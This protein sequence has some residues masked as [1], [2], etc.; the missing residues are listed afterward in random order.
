MNTKFKTPILL[1]EDNAEDASLIKG[2]LEDVGFKYELYHTE[3][4]YEG[5]ELIH[6]TPI[7]IVLL[8]LNLPDSSGFKTITSYLEKSA[9]VPVIVIT[10]MNNEII[11]NQAVKAGAQDFLIKGQFDSKIF[12]RSVRYSLQRSKVQ[13]KLEETARELEQSKKRFLDAQ[14]MAHLGTWDMDIVSSEMTWSDEVYRIFSFMPGG[15]SPTLSEYLTFVPLEDRPDVEA[16]F[17]NAAKDGRLH[18]IEHRI[19]I[20]STNIRYVTIQGKVQVDDTGKIMLAGN[21]QDT[22]ER[23]MSEKLL[24]EKNISSQTAK[25]QEAVLADLSFQIRTPLS[26]I[27]NLLFL[28]ENTDTGA[29]ET[30]YIGDLK[31]SVSDLSLSVNNLL[32]FSV[33]V[34]DNV[35]VEEEEFNIHEFLTGTQNIVK[36]KADSAKLPLKFNIDQQLPEKITGDPKKITQILYNLIDHA[37]SYPGED[38]KILVNAR[39]SEM[40]GNKFNLS[41]SINNTGIVISKKEIN[42]LLQAEKLLEINL[43]E[44]DDVTQKRKLCI[45]IVS[46]LTQT[47]G[48]KLTIASNQEK[49]TEFIISLPVKIPRQT[50]MLSGDAPDVP[51]KILLVEDHFLNQIA[52]KKVLTSWSE[53]VTVDIAENGLIAVEKF[54]EYGYDLILMDIQMPVMNG[55]DA[56]N[57]IRGFSNVPIIALTANSTKQEQDKCFE[58]GMND[59]LAKPFKPQ[60]LYARIMNIMSLVL[61]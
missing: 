5:I 56:A 30:S 14:K 45:A 37:M 36:I 60:E 4:L 15:I 19:L 51:L 16:F 34:A 3:T 39:G 22:T 59:Y 25:I 47:L 8:D 11:G 21:I 35:K 12:G 29:Q 26:S 38:A 17:E 54:R 6:K 2:Y 9:D 61:N 32:N 55:I 53:M 41:L 46:K 23:K 58:T 13:L 20:E 27:V 49:G 10:S 42:E 24:I 40:Q 33:M 18:Q 43:E 1:I 50:R 31:T 7:E 52:T 28:L 48:G 57:K 44:K